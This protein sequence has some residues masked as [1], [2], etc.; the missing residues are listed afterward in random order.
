MTKLASGRTLASRGPLRRQQ[1]GMLARLTDAVFEALAGRPD[2]FQSKRVEKVTS[3]AE[4]AAGLIPPGV[5][6]DA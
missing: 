3:D 5:H 6:D 2:V 1:G 4:L